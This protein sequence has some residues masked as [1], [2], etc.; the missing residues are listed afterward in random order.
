MGKRD[1]SQ[2]VAVMAACLAML[3]MRRP[4]RNIL[5]AAPFIFALALMIPVV[6]YHYRNRK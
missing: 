3:A 6:L 1:L 5:E 2:F 4:V